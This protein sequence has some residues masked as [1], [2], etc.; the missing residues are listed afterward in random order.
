M[1]DQ[2]VA[3]FDEQGNK[4]GKAAKKEVH[5]K[6]L[7]HRG[8]HVWIY[9]SKGE[10]LLQK[11]ADNVAYWPGKWDISAA[12]HVAFGEEPDDTALREL[13][14]ELGIKVKLN[15]LKKLFIKKSSNSAPELNFFNNEID[16][17]FL[18]RFDG[19]IS[20]LILQDS[21]VSNLRFISLKQLE[22]DIKTPNKYKDYVPHGQYYLKIMEAVKKELKL[23]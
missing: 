4:L 8:A 11:R 12:G 18:Y 14:E 19:D 21:E 1:A 5:L 10:I 20:K 16:S 2:I 9:N 23:Q 17:V 6:G 13:E 7:W 22:S 15:D 3:I